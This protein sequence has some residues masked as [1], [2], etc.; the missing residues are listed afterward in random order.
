MS[1]PTDKLLEFFCEETAIEQGGV[2]RCCLGS[3][4]REYLLPG[5]KVKIGD[6][7]ECKHCHQKFTLVWVRPDQSSCFTKQILDKT[8]IWK[9]DWQLQEKQP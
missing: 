4:A 2:M 3:V 7:S 9:P 6:K 8:P 1:G 5:V